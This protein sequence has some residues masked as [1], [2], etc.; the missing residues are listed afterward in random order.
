MKRRSEFSKRIIIF[1]TVFTLVITVFTLAL[2][3]RTGDTS[4]LA[5]LIPSVF[6]EYATA[7]GFYYWKARTENKIK[8]MRLYGKSAEKVLEDKQNYYENGDF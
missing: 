1:M 8:L 7:T 2:M 3:W 5:Y 6:A 4:P